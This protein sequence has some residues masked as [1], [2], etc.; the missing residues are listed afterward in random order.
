MPSASE[1]NSL[2]TAIG[3]ANDLSDVSMAPTLMPRRLIRF[4]PLKGLQSLRYKVDLQLTVK[5]VLFQYTELC[6]YRGAC[7]FP[8][9][10]VGYPV[11]LQAYME[12]ALHLDA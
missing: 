8:P 2:L 5:H 10:S 9:R 12:S 1:E 7:G 3:D 11:F 6:I 4:R